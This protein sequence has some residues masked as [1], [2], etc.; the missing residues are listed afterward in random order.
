MPPN[1]EKYAIYWVPRFGS[2]LATFGASWTGWCADAGEYRPRPLISEISEDLRP[3]L[4]KVR[5]H[6][7]H[8]KLHKAFP[9][10]PG[11]SDWA[12]ESIVEAIAD[13]TSLT[14]V[15]RLHLVLVNECLALA[16]ADGDRELDRLALHLTRNLAPINADAIH[17]GEAEPVMASALPGFADSPAVLTTPVGAIPILGEG[18]FHIPLTDP[19][20]RPLAGRFAAELAPL[21][22]P[23]LDTPQIIDEV[24]IVGDPGQNRPFRLLRRIGLNQDPFESHAA[25]LLTLG[26][27]VYAPLKARSH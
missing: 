13:T 20:P 8:G 1:F 9:L 26:P 17:P 14:V 7:F 5:L 3:Y 23:L 12:L 10:T 21:V 16:P 2:K 24:S 18:C 19:L 25:A 15:P 6:G 27:N 11:R 22:L 4:G